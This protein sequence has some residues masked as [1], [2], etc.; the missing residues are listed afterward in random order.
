MSLL[1]PNS[2]RRARELLGWTPKVGLDE[3]MRRTEIWFREQ[4]LL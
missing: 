4:G 3:G 2:N 1:A